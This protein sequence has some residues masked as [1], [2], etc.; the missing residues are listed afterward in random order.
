MLVVSISDF[1]WF[2]D[3]AL[4]EMMTIVGQLGDDTANRRPDLAGANSPYAILR[5]CLGV[6]EYWGGAMVAGRV[7]ARDR[8][9]EFRAHGPR[10]ACCCISSKSSRSTSDRCSFRATSCSVSARPAKGEAAATSWSSP[11]PGR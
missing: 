9:A 8:D 7:I 10:E 6:M 1:L 2:V 11:T 3:H 4:D 5:H